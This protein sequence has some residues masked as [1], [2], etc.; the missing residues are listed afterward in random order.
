MLL[1]IDCRLTDPL[2]LTSPV[3]NRSGRGSLD[4]FALLAVL[5]GIFYVSGIVN[6][7]SLEIELSTR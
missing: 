5:K 6:A 7:E 3:L 1:F 2:L 4:V